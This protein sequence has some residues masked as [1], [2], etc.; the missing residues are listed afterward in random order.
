MSERPRRAPWLTISVVL[1]L[2]L[3]GLIAGA[4]VLGTLRGPFRQGPPGGR[5]LY[6]MA[7][8]MSQMSPETHD[9]TRAVMDAHG[10]DLRGAIGNLRDAQTL[11]VAAMV[12]EPYDAAATG[13]AMADLR[14]RSVDLQAAIHDAIAA[15]AVNLTPRQREGLGRAL[16][17]GPYSGLPRGRGRNGERRNSGGN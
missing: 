15:I 11:A 13:T 12:A 8:M 10:P 16:F 17:H 6:G 7:G 1:N 3:V 9:M 4:V 5:G 14:M 2:F